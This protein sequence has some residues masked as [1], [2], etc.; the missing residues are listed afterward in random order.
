MLTYNDKIESSPFLFKYKQLKVKPSFR[1]YG[2]SSI[3][4]F[5]FLSACRK[6]KCDQCPAQYSSRAAFRRH[7]GSHVDVFPFSCHICGRKFRLKYSLND[8]T[9]T[10]QQIR[11]HGCSYCEKTFRTAKGLQNHVGI[12]TN[13]RAHKCGLCPLGFN[14]SSSCS[15]HRRLHMVNGFY[16]C[17]TC[18]FIINHF[19][20]FK[21]HLVACSPQLL[22]VWFFS[23]LIKFMYTKNA[24]RF[25]YYRFSLLYTKQVWCVV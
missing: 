2:S 12:H 13:E 9:R 23:N 18:G 3:V 25:E 6:Y 5:W 20:Q 21:D 11:R 8:H 1:L 10:H 17:E 15:L 19:V 7:L 14:F 24:I 16:R 22:F 4:R